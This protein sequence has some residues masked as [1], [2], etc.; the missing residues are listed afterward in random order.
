MTLALANGFVIVAVQGAIGAIER[1]QTPFTNWLRYSAILV[2]V[3]VLAVTWALARSS[4][5]GRRTAA[6]VLLIAAVAAVAGIVAMIVSTTYDY[7]LQSQLLTK[8]SSLH[9]THLIGA[10]G[11][12]NSAY[13]DGAWSPEQRDTLLADVKGAGLG[14][15]LLI[16]GNLLLVA[17]VTALRGGRLDRRRAGRPQPAAAPR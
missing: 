5:R 2:P 6:T 7:H 17:W 3:F 15:V 10:S 4:G 14:S 8:S 11:A 16:G 1:A 9:T 13:D 12:T